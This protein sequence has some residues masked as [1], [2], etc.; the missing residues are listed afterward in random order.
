MVCRLR[1]RRRKLATAGREHRCGNYM[2][3]HIQ[4]MIPRWLGCSLPYLAGEIAPRTYRSANTELTIS[5]ATYAQ[6]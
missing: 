4:T 2:Q 6:R 3:I 5:I 1:V